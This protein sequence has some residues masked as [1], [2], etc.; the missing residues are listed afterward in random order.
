[1]DLFDQHKL[2][3]VI[4]ACG[5]MTHL[6]GA[7]VLPDVIEAAAEAMGQFF[8]LDELQQAAGRVIADAT[9]AESGCVTACTAAGITLSI[10]AC[11]TGSDL[12]KIWQLP[13]HSGMPYR[14]LIQKGHC[15]N[16]G[17]PIT[18]AIRLAGAMPVEIGVVN[19]CTV[20]EIEYELNKPDVAAVLHVESHHTVRYGWVKLPRVVELAH[21]AG[22]PVIVDGAAQDLR[23]SELIG[24]GADLVISSAHKFLNSTTGGVVAGRKDL[25]DAVYLQNSGIGRPMKAGKEAIVGAMAALKHRNGQSI[26]Y[27]TAEQDRKVGAI[28]EQL[29]DVPGLTLSVDPDPN[30][31]PFSRVRLTPDPEVTGHTAASLEAA[32]MEGD[33]SVV[34]RAHHTDEGYIHLDAIDLTDEELAY[35]CRKT[36]AILTGRPL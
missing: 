2:T 28:L 36:R 9:G 5:K 30:G 16:Y 32:L 12:A 21:A 22:V 25:V 26:T 18:Q 3:R 29:R 1:M 27:W 20:E 13:D 19:R 10:A 34:P 7:R 35:A 11:M 8:V 33:P 23:L 24:T 17:H 14:V 31:C 15:V 4:N 6:S